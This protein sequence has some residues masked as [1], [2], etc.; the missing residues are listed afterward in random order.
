MA[1][2]GTYSK[3]RALNWLTARESLLDPGHD[4]NTRPSLTVMVLNKWLNAKGENNDAHPNAQR[5][6]ENAVLACLAW[7]WPSNSTM[8]SL[9]YQLG[10]LCSASPHR[11]DFMKTWSIQDP[12]AH[13]VL[14]GCK[15][16]END[17][18]PHLSAAIAYDLEDDGVP[19]LDPQ[20]LLL[21]AAFHW[22]AQY[23]PEGQ[24]KALWEETCEY[25]WMTDRVQ[26]NP[27]EAQLLAK[28]APQTMTTAICRGLFRN[29][30][31]NIDFTGLP[32]CAS[33]IFA[34]DLAQN[35]A[36]QWLDLLVPI[37]YVVNTHER[38]HPRAPAV[39]NAIDTMFPALTGLLQTALALDGPLA[40]SNVQPQREQLEGYMN[41]LLQKP[42][43]AWDA[44]PVFDCAV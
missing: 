37:H 7:Q 25:F 21:D 17:V 42:T 1:F 18:R 40:L 4:L 14:A 36:A 19:L 28:K 32:A 9:Y 15:H 22:V 38:V 24:H 41:A 20:D 33:V 44:G 13:V 10:H 34:M 30:N 27:Q 3:E 12:R 16:L 8:T 31:R 26:N 29:K 2:Y 43:P 11:L 5:W 39:W 35:S 6:I 23:E